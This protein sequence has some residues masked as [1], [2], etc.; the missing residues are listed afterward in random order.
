[1]SEEQK[2]TDDLKD[3]WVFPL[4]L[5]STILLAFGILIT[6][7]SMPENSLGITYGVCMII[8]GVGLSIITIILNFKP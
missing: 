2:E 7:F 6:V 3:F 4:T 1:M 8:G 5:V